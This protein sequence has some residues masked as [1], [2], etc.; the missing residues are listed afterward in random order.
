VAK[1]LLVVFLAFLVCGLT[2]AVSPDELE[3]SFSDFSAALFDHSFIIDYLLDRGGRDVL[4][5]NKEYQNLKKI[6]LSSVL[7]IQPWYDLAIAYSIAV[8]EGIHTGF[9]VTDEAEAAAAFAKITRED[10]AAVAKDL[11]AA[12]AA[13]NEEQKDLYSQIDAAYLPLEGVQLDA[14]GDILLVAADEVRVQTELELLKVKMSVK[15]GISRFSLGLFGNTAKTTAQTKK[16]EDELT[17]DQ[18]L[19]VSFE[20]INKGPLP[21]KEDFVNFIKTVLEYAQES[22]DDFEMMSDPEKVSDEDLPYFFEFARQETPDVLDSVAELESAW[23]VLT[24]SI[25]KIPK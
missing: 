8:I 20:L 15:K 5:N 10:L 2:T 7:A 19:K 14:A 4:D 24:D 22:A 6:T 11:E 17:K 12:I 9:N 21:P 25:N 23:D 1:Q 16:T 18:L 3:R 13:F